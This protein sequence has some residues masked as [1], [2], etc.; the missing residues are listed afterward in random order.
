MQD[1]VGSFVAVPAGP[2][3]IGINK[4]KSLLTNTEMYADFENYVNEWEDGYEAQ[5][6]EFQ[7]ARFPVLQGEFLK[8]V[9]ADKNGCKVLTKGRRR[10]WEEF[11]RGQFFLQSAP[12]FGVS[13]IEA[14]AYAADNGARLPTYEEWVRAARGDE[15]CNSPQDLTGVYWRG[16]LGWKVFDAPWVTDCYRENAW[17]SWTGAVDMMGNV[18]ELTSTISADRTRW[19]HAEYGGDDDLEILPAWCKV[20]ESGALTPVLAFSFALSIYVPSHRWTS[21]FRH[22]A[23]HHGFRL[24]R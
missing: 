20:M 18:S 12:V 17:T 13:M 7:I 6:E 22:I 4:A 11:A 23:P 15:V 19:R 24:A 8:W 2:A 9:L 3:R 16:D 14:L 21:R 1:S 10:H 5:I